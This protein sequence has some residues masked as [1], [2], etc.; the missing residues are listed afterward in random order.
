MSPSL[1]LIQ[2][3][4]DDREMYADYLTQQGL[5]VMEAA[6][7]DAALPLIPD[8]DV[9]I[10]GLMVPGA[11]PPIELIARI[12]RDPRTATKPVIALTACVLPEMR[13]RSWRAGAD[14]FLLKPCLPDMLLREV[15]R[16]VQMPVGRAPRERRQTPDR[17]ATWRGGRRESDRFGPFRVTPSLPQGPEA[18][19]RPR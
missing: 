16:V 17:R 3:G 13:D 7:T 15:R 10:T 4:A 9:I 6:T 11:V 12:R 1:L 2:V 18:Q 19:Y 5:R 14:V 8:V